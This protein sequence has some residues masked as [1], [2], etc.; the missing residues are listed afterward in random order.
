MMTQIGVEG[1]KSEEQ[2]DDYK[3]PPQ[4]LSAIGRFVSCK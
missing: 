4:R 2:L 1:K 3:L